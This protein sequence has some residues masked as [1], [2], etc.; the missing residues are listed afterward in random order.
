MRREVWFLKY[1]ERGMMRWEHTWKYV[2]IVAMKSHNIVT[3]LFLQCRKNTSL[4]KTPIINDVFIYQLMIPLAQSHM[5]IYNLQ[6]IQKF[7]YMQ[8]S[9]SL[10][11][12]DRSIIFIPL[13]MMINSLIFIL[14]LLINTLIF[15]YTAS[16]TTSQLT[17]IAYIYYY[18]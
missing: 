16:S 13:I 7:T 1:E 5:H 8:L 10:E 18:N 2:N 17:F 15:T 3:R 4:Y 12:L 6:Y 9:F 14:I 11:L